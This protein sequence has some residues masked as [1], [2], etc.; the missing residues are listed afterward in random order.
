MLSLLV[1]FL[2]IHGVTGTTTTEST[3]QT[4]IQETHDVKRLLSYARG[5]LQTFVVTGGICYF[6]PDICMYV[7]GGYI[8]YKRYC[9]MHSGSDLQAPLCAAGE[10]LE[11]NL[12]PVPVGFFDNVPRTSAGDLSESSFTL[13]TSHGYGS[14][15][16]D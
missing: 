4:T 1:G 15:A 5:I 8:G 10:I 2:I 3:D 9:S 16:V 6:T 14:F 7:T 12:L 13:S 11:R